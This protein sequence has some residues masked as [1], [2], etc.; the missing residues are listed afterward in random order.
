MHE[1]AKSR[2]PQM[3][4]QSGQGKASHF[5][6]RLHTASTSSKCHG[7]K[8]CVST[9]SSPWRYMTPMQHSL[10]WLVVWSRS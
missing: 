8:S 6:L 5:L 7:R 2:L 10:E 1:N 4:V 9:P 3:A